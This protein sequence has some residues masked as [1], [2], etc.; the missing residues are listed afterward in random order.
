MR[1]A[2][3]KIRTSFEYRWA[4]SKLQRLPEMADELVQ[5]KVALIVVNNA[6]RP[7]GPER[8]LHNP[9]ADPARTGLVA[10]G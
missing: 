1:S 7:D 9:G 4:Q 10:R 3:S 5:R 8:I 2:I 6:S